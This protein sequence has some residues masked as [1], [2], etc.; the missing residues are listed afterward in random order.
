MT[1]M[2]AMMS[3]ARKARRCLNRLRRRGM[4][5][6]FMGIRFF[7]SNFELVANKNMITS[8]EN[9][10]GKIRNCSPS[11]GFATVFFPIFRNDGGKVLFDGPNVDSLPAQFVGVWIGTPGALR[12]NDYT[13]PTGICGSDVFRCDG[14]E[15]CCVVWFHWCVLFGLLVFGC[16]GGLEPPAMVG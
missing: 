12:F 5:W 2:F 16:A 4:D 14:C 8:G 1:R 9:A 6:I 11:G 13:R 7:R 10:H 3:K 15:G